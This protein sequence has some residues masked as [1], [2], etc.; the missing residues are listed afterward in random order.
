[1][2]VFAVVYIHDACASGHRKSLRNSAP[3]LRD[4][5]RGQCWEDY[6]SLHIYACFQSS[7]NE[8]IR[9]TGLSYAPEFA[10]Y[11]QVRRKFGR[12]ECTEAFVV[13][14]RVHVLRCRALRNACWSNAVQWVG[15]I[16]TF[17]RRISLRHDSSPVSRS[18]LLK[19]VDPSAPVQPFKAIQP[20]ESTHLISNVIQTEG[21]MIVLVFEKASGAC[22]ALHHLQMEI[23]ER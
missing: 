13:E 4:G 15:P 1:M 5:R 12:L 20:R 19:S 10:S 3:L 2:A 18:C 11:L 8:W 16:W 21:V 6:Y 14:C 7:V 22:W 17:S 23:H 9:S